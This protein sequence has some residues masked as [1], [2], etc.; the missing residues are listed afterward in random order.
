MNKYIDHTLLKATASKEEII[1]LCREARA[2]DFAAV[3][4]NPTYVSL[5]SQLLDGS[6]VKVCTV[7]GFPLG[8]NT[9]E[10]KVQETKEAILTGANEI[11]MVINI[12]DL[13]AGNDKKVFQE[14][15]S[16]CDVCKGK[17]ILKVIVETCYLNDEEISRV[18]ML[19]RES[20]AAYI[21]TSTGFGTRGASLD[22]IKIMKSIVNDEIRI[23]ASGGIRDYETAKKMIDTGAS[24]I[25]TSSGVEIIKSFRKINSVYKD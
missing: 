7:V 12:A 10:N 18:S 14:I 13:I 16:V 9:L 11:D 19:V 1:D 17:A 6:G 4:V 23:K 3:C 21:K 20:G 8:A 25:G 15:K 24:R 2:Y 5:A 22:D